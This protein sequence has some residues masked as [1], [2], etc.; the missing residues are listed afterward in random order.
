MTI[1]ISVLRQEGEMTMTESCKGCAAY[2]EC[3]LPHDSRDELIAQCPCSTCI[4][5]SMC[6][7]SLCDNYR[8]FVV[9][10]REDWKT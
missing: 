5:K 4:V 8:K 1:E 7:V 3:G 2:H 10:I 9:I 6:S